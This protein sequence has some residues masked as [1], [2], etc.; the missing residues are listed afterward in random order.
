MNAHGVPIV[1][2]KNVLPNL[3]SLLVTLIAATR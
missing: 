1:D 2:L 3:K